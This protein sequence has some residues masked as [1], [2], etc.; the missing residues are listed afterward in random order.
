[1]S[2]PLT[3][4]PER[5]AEIH[6]L[7]NNA[8]WPETMHTLRSA[9]K[10]VLA[11]LNSRCEALA[12]AQEKLERERI[13][14]EDRQGWRRSRLTFWEDRALKAEQERDELRSQLEAARKSLWLGHGHIG[15][16]GDDG[17]MQCNLGGC[18]L[19]FKRDPL[20]KILAKLLTQFQAERALSDALAAGLEK[21]GR[22]L[23]HCNGYNKTISD[24]CCDSCGLSKLLAKHRAQRG[25]DTGEMNV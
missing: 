20:D 23:A 12:A 2:E 21:H 3:M 18:L 11:E 25:L 10:D 6:K 24:I 15:L 9:L 16:Y 4:T 8:E 14:N 19:D 1:M 5:E 7:G 22:H 13:S 17:E